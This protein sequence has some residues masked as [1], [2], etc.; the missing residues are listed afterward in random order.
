MSKRTQ[1]RYG[2]FKKASAPKPT[3]NTS[4]GRFNA[5]LREV[6][7]VLHSP[8]CLIVV[9]HNKL[10]LFFLPLQCADM[11]DYLGVPWVTA[12]GEAEAMCAYLD[13]QGLV[14]G[15]ITND[16]DAFLYGARTVYRN[17]NMNSKV[18]HYHPHQ[19]TTSGETSTQTMDW[20][21]I[22]GASL[23]FPKGSSFQTVLGISTEFMPL[24]K[25]QSSDLDLLQTIKVTLGLQVG[26][27]NF[28]M[29]VFKHKFPVDFQKKILYS[30]QLF[31]IASLKKWISNRG[32]VVILPVIYCQFFFLTEGLYLCIF[33]ILFL[34]IFQ[35]N[36]THT[37][38]ST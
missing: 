34:L 6:G 1:T 31:L 12:A 2:G 38:P 23:L 35:F 29:I 3:T 22:E 16:G 32:E 25:T 15:C 18:C 17:F 21:L 4:R 26:A 11:L 24:I 27:V 30:M 5:V 7:L 20:N 28:I 10:M 19:C 8:A 14:D 9:S 36:K 13:S 37:Y 33:D